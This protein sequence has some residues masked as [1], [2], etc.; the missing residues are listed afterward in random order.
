M[1]STPTGKALLIVQRVFSLNHFLKSSIPH[2]LGV[3][4]KVTTLAMGSMFSLRILYSV[5][6][7]YLESPQ[8]ILLQIYG[9]I[10]QT[11]HCCEWYVPIDWW[12]PQKILPTERPQNVSAT[13]PMI[14]GIWNVFYTT[15]FLVLHFAILIVKKLI[16]YYYFYIPLLPFF[17]TDNAFI[18]IFL[19]HI[20]KL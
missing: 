12:N 16:A 17:F 10:T 8:K 1:T 20:L 19:S 5:Y 14:S 9:S 7:R 2:N 4:S 18:L 6:K 3:A 15:I 11:R 13:L